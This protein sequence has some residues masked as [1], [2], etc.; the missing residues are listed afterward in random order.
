MKFILGL[1]GIT[2]YGIASIYCRHK[3]AVNY[4]NNQD[5]IKEFELNKYYEV[6]VS[7]ENIMFCPK[8]KT[9]IWVGENPIDMTPINITYG[10]GPPSLFSNSAGIYRYKKDE[11]GKFKL[12]TISRGFLFNHLN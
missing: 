1:C 2:S 12:A 10:W 4:I 3:K 8:L 5:I 9:I 6:I 7:Y 11:T